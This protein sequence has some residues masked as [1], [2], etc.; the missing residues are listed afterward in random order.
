MGYLLDE[1]V[2]PQV[3]RLLRRRGIEAHALRDH[4]GGR[5]LQADDAELLRAALRA[6][7]VFVTF[8]VHTVPEVLRFFAESGE[9]HGGVVLVS[10]R[11]FPQDDVGGLAEALRQLHPELERRGTR[12]RVVFLERHP[13]G[14]STASNVPRGVDASTAGAGSP[15][16]QD[17]PPRPHGRQQGRGLNPASLLRLLLVETRGFEPPTPWLQRR[18]GDC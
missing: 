7:L 1:H 3:A 5:L 13:A 6:G 14:G 4:E 11:S 12:N 10:A 2:S 16:P 15:S 17:G 8:D 18:R 9:E